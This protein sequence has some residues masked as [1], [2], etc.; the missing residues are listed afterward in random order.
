M[1]IIT[2]FV[3]N[4]VFLSVL[5]YFN[6]FKILDN[7]TGSMNIFSLIIGSYYTIA[8]A[9]SGGVARA[10]AQGCSALLI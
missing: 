7:L 8:S 10:W 5:L 1:P 2:A 6:D 9:V 4:G 3:V